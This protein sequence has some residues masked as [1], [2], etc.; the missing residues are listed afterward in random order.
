MWQAFT[1]QGS[2]K[3]LSFPAL[4]GPDTTIKAQ[5]LMISLWESSRSQAAGLGSVLDQHLQP[6]IHPAPQYEAQNPSG[7]AWS[8]RSIL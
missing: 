1:C 2:G 5:E 8:T 4:A 3:F 7:E 6:F